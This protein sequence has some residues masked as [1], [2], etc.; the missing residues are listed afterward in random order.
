MFLVQ[1]TNAAVYTAIGEGM[2]MYGLRGGSELFDGKGAQDMYEAAL[3][4]SPGNT[5]AAT[6]VAYGATWA[7]QA[8]ALMILH[9]SHV[10]YRRPI[11]ITDSVRCPAGRRRRE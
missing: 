3:A 2:T 11:S 5:C 1:P 6:H 7:E 9:N 8:V 4:L 10:A